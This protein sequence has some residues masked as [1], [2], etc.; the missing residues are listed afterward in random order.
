MDFV[1]FSAPFIAVV[2]GTNRPKP[3]LCPDHVP[4][5][6]EAVNHHMSS[7]NRQKAK[8]PM[9]PRERDEAAG[10]HKSVNHRNVEVLRLVSRH[11]IRLKDVIT[12]KMC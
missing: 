10:V 6:P 5:Q 1:A 8:W 3:V 2:A 12:K 7:E 9:V 4:R 11:P